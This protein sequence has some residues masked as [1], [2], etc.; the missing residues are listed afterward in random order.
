MTNSIKTIKTTIRG[1]NFIAAINSC[2]AYLEYKFNNMSG[3]DL[4][5]V[6]DSNL[7]PADEASTIKSN[8]LGA[9]I[10][11]QQNFST[12]EAA[13]PDY[14]ADVGITITLYGPTT[15]SDED[16]LSQSIIPDSSV[17]IVDSAQTTLTVPYDMS[18]RISMT[19][20]LDN[21]ASVEIRV[22]GTSTVSATG[23]ATNSTKNDTQ[24]V[25]LSEGD[26]LTFIGD[27]SVKSCLATIIILSREE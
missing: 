11:I 10:N 4:V 20:V 21:S 12:I 16:F 1:R 25:N 19:V 15:L 9:F 26:V 23:T 24:V 2:F 6:I 5:E 14:P 13:V 7:R 8:M 27:G 3:V 18:A 22:N 17:F